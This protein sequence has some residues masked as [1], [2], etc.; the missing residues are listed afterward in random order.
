MRECVGSLPSARATWEG[1]G[2]V[3]AGLIVLAH[4]MGA[5]LLRKG[6][7]LTGRAREPAKAGA[8]K[9]ATVLMGRSRWAEREG[10]R[11]SERGAAP[12]GGAR[13]S[14]DAGARGGLAGPAWA[15]RPRREG[16]RAIF[17]FP[18]IF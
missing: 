1:R 4:A 18:F 5:R 10:E 12:I 2:D 15:E 11:A 16:V 14:V 17:L 9:R 6:A 3:G 8:H 13:L 7:G